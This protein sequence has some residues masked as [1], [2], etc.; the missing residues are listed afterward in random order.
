MNH[1]KKLFSSYLKAAFYF[2]YLFYE[3]QVHAVA[4]HGDRA[5]QCGRTDADQDLA[6][7]FGNIGQA[8]VEID[9]HH[10]DQ[11]RSIHSMSEVIHS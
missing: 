4:E 6:D 9:N 2:V 7:I 3:L 10:S 8:A 5:K 1:N 11:H